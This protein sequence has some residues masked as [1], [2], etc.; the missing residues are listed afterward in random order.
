MVPALKNA[1][2]GCTSWGLSWRRVPSARRLQLAAASRVG[3]SRLAVLPDQTGID[4]DP[5][6]RANAPRARA[7]QRDQVAG[8]PWGTREQKRRQPEEVRGAPEVSLAREDALERM[9]G[10]EPAYSLG[11]H[12]GRLGMTRLSADPGVSGLCRRH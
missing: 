7:A 10:I 9:T 3:R 5:A 4:P 8:S 12:R 11:R 2:L 1:L 6:C